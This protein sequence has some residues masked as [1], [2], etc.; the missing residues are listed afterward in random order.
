MSLSGVV[1]AEYKYN[2]PGHQVIRNLT[3]AGQIIHSI[4]DLDGN[5]IAEYD[6]DDVV[7]TSSLIREYRRWTSSRHSISPSERGHRTDTSKVS[8][9]HFEGRGGKPMVIVTESGLYKLVMRSDKP[10]AKAFQDWVTGT[11]LPSIRKDGG[12]IMGEGDDRPDVL[13]GPVRPPRVA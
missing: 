2:A 5:R 8:R 12:Y 1:Q 3:Q 6:Y 9:S 4:H 11:V 10:E 7:L 13:R